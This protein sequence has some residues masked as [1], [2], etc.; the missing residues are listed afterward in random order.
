[1]QISDID[2]NFKYLV[3]TVLLLLPLVAAHN[4]TVP[5]QDRSFAMCD[6]STACQGTEFGNTC[7]GIE[8]RRVQCVDPMNA[9]MYRRVEAECGLDAQAICNANPELTGLE[10]TENPNAS[11]NGRSCS[12]WAEQ[13][14]RIDLL[15]CGQTF[16]SVQHWSDG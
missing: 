12:R 11:Y 8:Q 16:D 7:L 3:L 14:E 9:S 5:E 4:L 6:R 2:P 15:N 10:W 1:M 13:D